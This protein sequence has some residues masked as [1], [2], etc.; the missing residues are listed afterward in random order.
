MYTT[1][2]YRAAGGNEIVV[3]SGGKITMKPGSTLDIEGVITQSVTFDTDYF[4]NNDGE[5]TLKASV[6]ALLAIV[7]G[8]PTADP[9]VAGQVYLDGTTLKVSEGEG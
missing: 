4:E 8:I 6:V 5:I 2:V 9:E 1:K 3:E 7:D